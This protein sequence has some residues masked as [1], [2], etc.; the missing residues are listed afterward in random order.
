MP[1]PEERETYIVESIDETYPSERPDPAWVRG[2]C[3]LCG[4]VVIS[5]LYYVGGRGYIL[6]WECW[7]SLGQNPTCT[8]QKVL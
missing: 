4:D 6:R 7:S 3:P 2:K 8:Y 1:E 5:N